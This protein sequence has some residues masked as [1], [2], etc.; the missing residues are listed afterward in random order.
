L[1]RDSNSGQVEG[2]L[3][4]EASYLPVNLAENARS[5]GAHV[6]EC[7]DYDSLIKGIKEAQAHPKTTVI[8]TTCD[9]YQG[10]EGYGWWDVPIAQVSTSNEVNKAREANKPHQANQ[11]FYY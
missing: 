3:T 1:F 5:L 10:V 2:D 4:S 8:Y 6:I 11:R 7:T 9:R